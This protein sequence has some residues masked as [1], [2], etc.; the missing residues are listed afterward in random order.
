L[1]AL[2]KIF[3]MTIAV[4]ACD[5]IIVLISREEIDAP[6]ILWVHSAPSRTANME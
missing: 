2:I 6:E 4:Q 1:E 3:G 5:L